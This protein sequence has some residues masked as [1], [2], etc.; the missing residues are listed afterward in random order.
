MPPYAA[1][2]QFFS[3]H[4][5]WFRS[6]PNVIKEGRFPPT[7][8]SFSFQS[9]CLIS[10]TNTE[11]LSIILS[12]YFE[13][14]LVYKWE[15]LQHT[16]FQRLVSIG[17]QAGFENA[18]IITFSQIWNG[19]RV[20]SIF[21]FAGLIHFLIFRGT[22]VVFKIQCTQRQLQWWAEGLRQPCA[23]VLPWYDVAHRVC[24]MQAN[25]ITD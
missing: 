15:W 17:W 25:K 21:F 16:P 10:F 4:T 19:P 2:K 11:K 8:R 3:C 24:L 5:V 20:V 22:Y 14:T 1:Y 6:V 12:T 7:Q 9:K 13:D 23:I 18:V